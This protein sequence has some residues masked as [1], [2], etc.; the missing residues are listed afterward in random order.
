MVGSGGR[1]TRT[2]LPGLYKIYNEQGGLVAGFA[3]HAGSALESNLTPQLQPETF[4]LQSATINPLP[5]KI[6]YYDIWPWLVGLVVV[7]MILEGWLAWRK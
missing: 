7:V 3:V 6:E 1:F 4:N 5:P 2:Q